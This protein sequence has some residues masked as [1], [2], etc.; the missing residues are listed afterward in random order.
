MAGS[1]RLVWPDNREAELGLTLLLIQ[2]F[3]QD[4]EKLVQFGFRFFYSGSK[5][6]AHIHSVT[7]Q[8]IIPF[9]RDYKTYVMNSLRPLGQSWW[10][11]CPTRFS[12]CTAT[13]AKPV[14]L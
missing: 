11:R 14:K 4:P 10:C 9:V 1:A 3:A 7:R 6:V 2:K 13:M 8:M 5:I 12:L